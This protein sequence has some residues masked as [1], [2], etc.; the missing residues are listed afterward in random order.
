M[1]YVKF[2]W[3][4]LYCNVMKHEIKQVGKESNNCRGILFMNIC[5]MGISASICSSD[6][7]D[8]LIK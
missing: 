1:Y 7:C 5:V 4:M 3:F 8:T 6:R 2:L